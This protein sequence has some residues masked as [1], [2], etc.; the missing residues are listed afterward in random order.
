MGE[1][2]KRGRENRGMEGTRRVKYKGMMKEGKKEGHNAGMSE[3]G[4]EEMKYW[5]EEDDIVKI[6][7][8]LG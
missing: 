7:R 2:R 6:G 4:S 3:A 1:R 8:R 5:T